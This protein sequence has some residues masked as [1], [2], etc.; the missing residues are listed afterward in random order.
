MFFIT[1][2][3][4][5][6]LKSE[7]ALE[8]GIIRTVGYIETLEEV[9]KAVTENW[10]DMQ[11][12]IYKFAVI[13][14]IYPAIYP[15]VRQEFWFKWNKKDRSFYPVENPKSLSKFWNFALG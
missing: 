13:E 10:C 7:G 4:K 5:V 14:E 6:K 12:G 1:L 15:N 11:K 3:Q 8:C 9:K 2:F